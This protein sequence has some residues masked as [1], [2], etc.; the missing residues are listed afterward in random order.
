[1]EDRIQRRVVGGR[2]T[3]CR[4]QRRRRRRRRRRRKSWGI[5]DGHVRVLVLVLLLLLKNSPGG[6]TNSLGPCF[7]NNMGFFGCRS[8]EGAIYLTC[9]AK[10]PN[11]K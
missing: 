11:Q 1:M 2:R 10:D 6:V 4:G 5:G 3:T 9:T 7:T 8:L